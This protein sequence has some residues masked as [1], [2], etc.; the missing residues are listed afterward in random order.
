MTD[1][2]PSVE[3]RLSEAKLRKLYP[4]LR[5]FAAVVAPAEVG[6]DDLLQEAFERFLTRPSTD[7][8]NLEA[9]LRRV[10]VNTASNHRRRLGRWRRRL[11]QL[12][13]R[14]GDH[15]ALD[16]YPSDVS[17]LELISPVERAVLFLHDVEGIGFRD[18]GAQLGMTEAASKQV[19]A[20]ARRRLRS[21][22]EQE[23]TT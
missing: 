18:V 23:E 16:D 7:V 13:P 15:D 17:F 11:H 12:A 3:H 22:L 14:R 19:A 9:Y 21:H 20:R 8:G 6:P 4:S 5:R 2:E 10:I 1:T